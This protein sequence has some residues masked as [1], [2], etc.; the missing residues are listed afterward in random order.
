MPPD[1]TIR[2]FHCDDSEPF[3][4]L[5]RHWLDEHPDIVWV[6]A[7]HDRE[8]VGESVAA[9]RPDVV[10]LDTMGTPGNGELLS[11]VRG[12][13]PDARV[14]VYSGYVGLMGAGGLAGGADAYVDKADD[15][16]ALVEAVRTVARRPA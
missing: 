11:V 15:E 12:A 7:E 14:I 6:G 1:G 2:V 4:L 16:S 13:A 3:T 10:L 5:V 8:R 9:A